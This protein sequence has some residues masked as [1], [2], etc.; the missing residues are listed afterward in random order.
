MIIESAPS[1]SEIA[2]KKR[3]AELAFDEGEY[4]RA[5]EMLTFR[6]RIEETLLEYLTQNP[7]AYKNAFE[8]LS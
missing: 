3:V 8:K 2:R 6:D 1:K 5:R 4:I 7:N